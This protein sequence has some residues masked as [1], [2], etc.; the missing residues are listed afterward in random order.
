MYNTDIPARAELPTS[1]QLK[2]ST[3]IAALS[4]AFILVAVVMP[5]DYGI[6]PTG[7]G[8]VLRLTEMGQI[9][10][11]L[12]AEAA[13]DAVAA[14]TPGTS[15]SVAVA[16]A[17]SVTAVAPAAAPTAEPTPAA[18]VSTQIEWRDTTT[19]TLK[20]GEG[21]EVKMAMTEG[22]KAQYIWVVEA[23]KVNYDAHGDGSGKS[24]SYKKGRNT[25]SEEGVMTAAFTGN[26]GWFWRNRGESDVKLILRTRGEY[27]AIKKMM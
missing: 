10:T 12:A 11:K 17:T 21:T 23:G 1:A 26:H 24:T 27:S 7:L 4:A 9:K 2:R 5:A 8:R 13:A 20:P 22:A 18:K 19:I 6:D 15:T 16:P 25:S 3:L 14:K